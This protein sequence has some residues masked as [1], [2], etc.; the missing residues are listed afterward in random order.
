MRFFSTLQINIEMI[1]RWPW[2]VWRVYIGSCKRAKAVSGN[3]DALSLCRY[4][5]RLRHSEVVTYW[6]NTGR[7]GHLWPNYFTKSRPNRRQSV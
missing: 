4:L 6:L 2:S 1:S 7:L 5:E 3:K